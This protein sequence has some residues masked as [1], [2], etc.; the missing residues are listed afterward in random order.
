MCKTLQNFYCFFYEPV[1]SK[2]HEYPYYFKLISPVS[3]LI[4]PKVVKNEA[5]K[6]VFLEVFKLSI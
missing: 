1:Y 6:V 5:P 2:I 4:N 3:I